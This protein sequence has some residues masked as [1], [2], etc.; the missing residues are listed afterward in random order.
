MTD[1]KQRNKKRKSKT[2]NQ[3]HLLCISTTLQL[4][5]SLLAA[6]SEPTRPWH[7]ENAKEQQ[8]HTWC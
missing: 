1:T 8:K 3:M 6:R 5:H 2:F 7:E 4:S